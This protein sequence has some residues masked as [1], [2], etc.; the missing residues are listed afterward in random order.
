MMAEIKICGLTRPEDARAAQAAGATYGGVILAEGSPRRVDADDVTRIFEGVGLRRCG[1]FV[2]ADFETIAAAVDAMELDV[3]QLH[4]D[5]GPELPRRLR[6][7]LGIEVWKALRPRTGEEFVA[8]LDQFAAD[9]DG[10]LLDGWSKTARGWT[11]TAFPWEEIARHR[12]RVPDTMRLV[13]AGG[14][15]PD[16]V[17]RVL[18]LLDPDAVD[19]SSGVESSPGKKDPQLIDE[20]AGAVRAA[21]AKKE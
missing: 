5:E 19:V 13:V 2:N 7:E 10:V 4:G 18:S 8:G 3:V 9:V 17:A 20:F 1:V 12:S 16:N 11:G 15:S 6:A 21:T 14:L